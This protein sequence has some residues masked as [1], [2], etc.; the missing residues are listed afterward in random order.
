MS[1]SRLNGTANGRR[2]S[3]STNGANGTAARPTPAASE[4]HDGRGRFVKNNAGGSGNPWCRKVASVR[5]ALLESVGEKGAAEVGKALVRRV[6]EHGDL[7]ACELLLKWTLGAPALA[8][9][10]D[11]CDADEATRAQAAVPLGKLVRLDAVSPA[12]A[13]V[14]ARVVQRVVLVLAANGQVGQLVGSEGLDR[15]FAELN[16]PE[17]SEW[18]AEQRADAAGT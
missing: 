2:R 7:A 4:A 1:G 8:A 11:D 15:L 9:G 18:L 10:P 17:L 12:V 3:P 5:R 6:V 14:L 13:A 16:D